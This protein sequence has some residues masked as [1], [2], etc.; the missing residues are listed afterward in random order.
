VLILLAP[1][2]YSV[3]RPRVPGVGCESPARQ[4]PSQMFTP[5]LAL[6]CLAYVSITVASGL[7]LSGETMRLFSALKLAKPVAFV[8]VGM[9][10]G[11]WV[12]PSQLFNSISRAYAVLVGMLLAFTVAD[13]EFPNCEWGKYFFQFEISGYPNSPM[14]FFAVLVPLL[15]AT[16]DAAP[17]RVIR[18]SGRILAVAS[19]ILVIGS[20]SRSS[21]LVLFF[22]TAVYLALT[23]RWKF[24]VICS[25]LFAILAVLGLGIVSASKQTETTRK[26][27]DRI[28][29]RVVTIE[30]GFDP[31][32]GR[33][34][35]WQFILELAA[36]KPVFGYLFEPLSRHMGDVESAHQQYLEILYKC[37]GVGL[38]LFLA[39]LASCLVDL[40]R[41]Q[42]AAPRESLAW[43]Q[44]NAVTGMLVGI[45]L[46]NL[47]QSNLT[48]SLTGNVLFMIFGCLNGART[49]EAFGQPA[50]ATRLKS[51]P[52][53]PSKR[54]A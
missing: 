33:L 19:T 20:L 54:A 14:S 13:R 37:G 10:L 53:I 48:Y 32:N 2:A 46:G 34:E 39:L 12:N 49:A 15:L 25:G 24:L 9:V 16:A 6:I 43:Y 22:S 26:P 38:L 40:K 4:V 44:L 3:S 8:F 17:Q 5:V 52:P 1:L 41:L 47:T 36:E 21:T 7:A 31:S 42:K 45:L 28:Q 50:Q 29:D 11:S 18:Y 51:V 23:G 35:I 30:E 27:S